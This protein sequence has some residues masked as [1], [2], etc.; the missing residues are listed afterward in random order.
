[1]QCVYCQNYHFSQQPGG[2]EVGEEELARMMLTLQEK[3]CHNINLVTPTHQIPQIIAALNIAASSGLKV[4]IV[5]N[6]S[7][8]ELAEVIKLLDGI[9]DIYLADLRYGDEPSGA[10][11]SKAKDYPKYSQ[12]ALIEMQRQVGVAK[13]SDEGIME[14]GLIVRHLVLPNGLSGTQKAMRFIAEELSPDTFISLMSQYLPVYKAAEFKE[15][16]RRI[17]LKEYKDAQKSMGKYGLSNGWVQ[18][19]RGL[20]KLAG[21]H[22]KPNL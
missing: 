18:E 3:G 17:T 7:G 11:Y 8:Y 13:I 4:P 12:S 15:L 22:L 5:Y 16:N 21:I 19:A 6:T 14:R 1:M 2:K 9:V 20:E 10:R